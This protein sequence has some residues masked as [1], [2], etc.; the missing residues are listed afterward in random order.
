MY[1]SETV[2]RFIYHVPSDKLS[3]VEVNF[4]GTSRVCG[5]K[6]N[7]FVVYFCLSR[8][9]VGATHIEPRASQS[10]WTAAALTPTVRTTYLQHDSPN[11]G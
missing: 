5:S 2:G 8:A 10:A 9:I 4:V 1:V 3:A 7:L 11:R 6:P